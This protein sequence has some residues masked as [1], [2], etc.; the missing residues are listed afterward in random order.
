[1]DHHII[2]LFL[3]LPSSTTILCM[4][5]SIS[6]SCSCERKR[7]YWAY[8]FVCVMIQGKFL[9]CTPQRS[10]SLSSLHLK[11]SLPRMD[12][13]DHSTTTSPTVSI[14]I[15]SQSI[16]PSFSWSVPIYVVYMLFR[17]ILSHRSFQLIV[18]SILFGDCICLHPP[19]SLL[20]SGVCTVE[21]VQCH[22]GSDCCQINSSFIVNPLKGSKLTFT[23][24]F[25]D[26]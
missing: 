20:C 17:V 3:A 8:L 21:M 23:I 19:A 13:L 6:E 25:C 22:W 2:K 12:S 7:W 5:Y 16:L 24:Q 14:S 26:R 11:I 10:W 4:L 1:M 18:P 15:D 9:V